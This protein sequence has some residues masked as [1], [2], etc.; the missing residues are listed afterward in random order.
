M[1]CTFGEHPTETN[2]EMVT[3][4]YWAEATLAYN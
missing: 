4:E 2:I 3:L 1:T